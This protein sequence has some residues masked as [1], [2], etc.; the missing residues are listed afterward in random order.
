MHGGYS[1]I[2]VVFSIYVLWAGRQHAKM[3]Q[4]PAALTVSKPRCA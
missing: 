4:P 2:K 1:E 3:P